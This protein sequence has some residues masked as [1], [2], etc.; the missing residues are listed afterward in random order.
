MARAGALAGL[1]DD[2]FDL[3]MIDAGALDVVAAPIDLSAIARDVAEDQRV[4]HPDGSAIDVGADEVAWAWGDERRTRQVLDNLVSNAVKFSTG[5][6]PVQISVVAQGQEVCVMVHNSGP[7]IPAS[8]QTRIFDRF[9]RLRHAAPAP[10]SGLG[11]FIARS[12]VEA[13]G[14]RIAVTSTDAAGT[15][16]TVALPAL[17]G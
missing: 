9:V 17:E 2:I 11:L 8:E 6:D 3:A 1:T 15:T 16:F 4:V 5:D 14:G 10:G 12:L 13:Q 7:A